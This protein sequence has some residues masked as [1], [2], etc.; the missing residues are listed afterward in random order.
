MVI[1]GN[2]DQLKSTSETNEMQAT[3]SSRT[4]VQNVSHNKYQLSPK[5]VFVWSVGTDIKH[6]K[7]H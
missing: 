6:I 7:H 4:V 5:I 2:K 3:M 1:K